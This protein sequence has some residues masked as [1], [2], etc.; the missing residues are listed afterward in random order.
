MTQH[1][2]L[3][4]PLFFECLCIPVEW[5]QAISKPA[6]KTIT[7]ASLKGDLLE[8]MSI[9]T[10]TSEKPMPQF[11]PWEKRGEFFRLKNNDTEGLL[12]FLRSVGLLQRTGLGNIGEGVEQSTKAS[13]G[14]GMPFEVNYSPQV[15]AS[16]IWGLRELIKGSLE[17]GSDELG[18]WSDFQ[19]RIVRTK[20]GPRIMLTTT[21]FVDAMLLTLNVDRVLRAK[22]RKCAR[23]DCPALFSIT[24]KYKKKYCTW[25]CGHVESVR[26]QRRRAKQMK[27]A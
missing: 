1:G 24:E 22:V 12:R 3:N 5:R 20:D 14:R 9:S 4:L 8:V 19:T 17:T 15:R 21:T 2:R 23:P 13:S 7:L 27:R 26:R 10:G 11:D 6:A 16:N 25:D 18:D